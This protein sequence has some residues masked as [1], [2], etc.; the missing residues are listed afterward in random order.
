MNEFTLEHLAEL[1]AAGKEG[2]GVVWRHDVDCDLAAAVTVA[3]VEAEEG[4]TSTFYLWAR[5][6]FYNLFGPEG[7]LTIHTLTELGHRLGLHVDL[8]LPRDADVSDDQ[9]I[10]ALETDYSLA[11]EVYG[12]VWNGGFSVHKPPTAALWRRIPGVEY[13]YDHIWDGFYFSDSRREMPEHLLA[14]LREPGRLPIQ[15]NLHPEQWAY[16]EGDWMVARDAR[17]RRALAELEDRALARRGE[18]GARAAADGPPTAAANL[19]SVDTITGADLHH[20]IGKALPRVKPWSGA[21]GFRG[22]W[23]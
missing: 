9:L 20:M 19:A 14:T 12:D 22:A 10:D 4:V 18:P 8:A 7:Q 16:P 21:V 3:A 11:F 6:P 13:A 17:H 15:V 2:A 1:L 23:Y 5:S